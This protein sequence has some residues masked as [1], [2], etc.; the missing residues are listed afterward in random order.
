[1][2]TNGSDAGADIPNEGDV[3]T[4]EKS[5]TVEDVCEFAEV[6]G[7]QQVI[8]TESDGEDQAAVPE[9]LTGSLMTNIGGDLSYIA[10][11]IKFDFRRVI[12]SGETI[13][14]EWTV[15]SKTER[16]DRHLLENDVV[17]YDEDGDIVGTGGTTGLIWK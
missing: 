1:M 12:H 14:C 5:F 2:T 4:C 15:E 13:I 8:D 11:T 10:R 17:Y 9:L 7:N 6:S 16:E 3:I